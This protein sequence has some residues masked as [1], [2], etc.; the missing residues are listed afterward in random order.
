MTLDTLVVVGLVAL[1]SVVAALLWRAE[2]RRDAAL[3]SS[4]RAQR[5][6]EQVEWDR[7]VEKNRE[8]P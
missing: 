4:K 5:L 1:L 7:L 8:R 2:R 3:K 6:Q